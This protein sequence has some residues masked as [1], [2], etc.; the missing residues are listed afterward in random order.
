MGLPQVTQ[1]TVF[2][3]I[4]NKKS[5][6]TAATA[7]LDGGPALRLHL[8]RVGYSVV[9]LMTLGFGQHDTRFARYQSIRCNPTLSLVRSPEKWIHCVSPAPVMGLADV[10]GMKETAR[11]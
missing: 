6:P 9:T 3:L 8:P 7:N 11:T 1:G 4:V 2:S 10:S 5:R